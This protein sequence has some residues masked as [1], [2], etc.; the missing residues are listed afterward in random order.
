VSQC[1]RIT[2]EEGDP[3]DDPTDLAHRGTGDRELG[4]PE[5]AGTAAPHPEEMRGRVTFSLG[6][7]ATVTAAGRATPAGLVSAALL[8]G[9]I[10]I[11]IA[12]MVRRRR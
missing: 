1:E 9:A 11:P 12:W 7:M 3:M 5:P 6:D 4:A 8:V 10:M 2:L